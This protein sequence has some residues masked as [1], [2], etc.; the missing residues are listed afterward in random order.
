MTWVTVVARPTLLGRVTHNRVSWYPHICLREKSGEYIDRWVTISRSMKTTDIW[1][2]R[3]NSPA[4]LAIVGPVFLKV[5][6]NKSPFL[7][8]VSTNKSSSVIFGLVR[9]IILS[10]NRLDVLKIK[11]LKTTYTDCKK[12]N[13]QDIRYY[14]IDS[15]GQDNVQLPLQ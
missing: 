6:K 12:A 11:D 1:Q 13:K 2:G 7:Q 9:L 10:Y 15:N 5:R 8:I 14:S 4:A 3:W